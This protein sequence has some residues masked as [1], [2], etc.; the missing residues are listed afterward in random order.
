MPAK[1]CAADGVDARDSLFLRFRPAFAC[2]L[3]R[4]RQVDIVFDAMGSGL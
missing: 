4:F 3:V 2:A 1:S